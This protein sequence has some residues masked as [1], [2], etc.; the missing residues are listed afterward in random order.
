MISHAAHGPWVDMHAHPGRCFLA[1][2]RTDDLLTVALGPDTCDASVANIERAGIAAVG[3]AT[4]SDLQVLGFRDDG[5]L[6]TI[7][8]FQDGEAYADHCRQLDGLDNLARRHE[9]PIVRRADDILAAHD[10][11]ATALF[12]TCEGADF[13]EDDLERLDECHAAGVRSITLVHYRQNGYGDLQTE[14]PAH[15]GLSPAGRELVREM[16]RMGLLIDLAHATYETTLDVLE[17]SSSP[18]VISHTHLN[19]RGRDHARLV[20]SEHAAAVASAGGLVG[21]WPAGVSSQ[22]FDDF[23]DEIV[24]LVDA[25]GADHVG[26]GTDMDANYKPVMDDYCQFEAIEERLQVRGLTPTEV[27]RILGT[28][29]VELIRNVCG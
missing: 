1:G 3:F 6:H 26:I 19:G 18:V 13:V 12:I 16:N 22:T 2:L 5:G 15:G 14:P 29:A 23:V 20:S 27:D 9:L 11:G 28:N 8:P 4:V 25:I 24:R 17:E 21:A 10:A 7:R